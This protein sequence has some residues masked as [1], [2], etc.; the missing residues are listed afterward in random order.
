MN[1]FEETLSSLN[2]RQCEAVRADKNVVVTAGA[3]SGKTTVLSA[4]YAYLIM[5]RNLDTSQILTL[6]FTNKATNEMF[7]RIYKMLASSSTEESAQ[8]ALRNFYEA[9]I[10]TIDSFC[11]GLA[12]NGAA[13]FGISPDWKT[14]EAALEEL[15]SDAALAFVLER[16]DNHALQI[17]T[18]DKKINLISSGLFSSVILNETS[19]SN[20]VDFLA[21]LDEQIQII[22]SEYPALVNLINTQQMSVKKNPVNMPEAADIKIILEETEGANAEK[23]KLLNYYNMLLETGTKDQKN[24]FAP[25][26]NFVL[27]IKILKEIY[28]LLNDFQSLCNTQK[29]KTGLL[30]FNDVAQLAA[31]TLKKIPEIKQM[32]QNEIKA[33]MVDEFQD[34]NSAQKELLFLLAGNAQKLF[35]VGDEKQSIYRFRGADVSVFHELSKT[36]DSVHLETNYRSRSSLIGAFNILFKDIFTL[37]K[38]PENYDAEFYPLEAW[39]SAGEAKRAY[40]HFALFEEEKIPQNDRNSIKPI[41]VEA[42]YIAQK[43]NSIVRGN[44][45]LLILKKDANGESEAACSFEDIAVLLRRKTHQNELERELKR[46]DIPYNAE[47]PSSLFNDAFI[48]DALNFMRLL[49]YPGDKLSYMALLRSPFARLSDEALTAIVLMFNKIPFNDAPLD[50]LNEEDKKRYIKIKENYYELKKSLES[51]TVGIT[52]LLSILWNDFGYRFESLCRKG[53]GALSFDYFFELAVKAETRNKTLAQ[54]LHEIDSYKKQGF[55][56]DQKKLLPFDIPVE[57]DTGVRILTVHKSKGLEFPVVFIFDTAGTE[58][59]GKNGGA[60]FA[61]RRDGREPL[62]T[63]NL[64]QAAELN[65]K[66]PQNYFYNKF[67]NDEKNRMA[68]ELRRLVYVAA[69][70]AESELYWTGTI[71]KITKAELKASNCKEEPLPF[72]ERLRLYGDK[73]A[74]KAAKKENPSSILD[75]IAPVIVKDSGGFWDIEQIKYS[76]HARLKSDFIKQEAVLKAKQLYETAAVEDMPHTAGDFGLTQAASKNYLF[77]GEAMEAAGFGSLVH[78]FIETRLNGSGIAEEHQKSAR[79]REAEKL[80]GVFF[81]SELGKRALCAPFRVTEYPFISRI[82]NNEGKEIYTNGRVDLIFR[83]AGGLCIVDYKTDKNFE[84]ERYIEQLLIYR[85]AAEEI[86]GGK[87]TA[88][89]FYLRLNK[90]FRAENT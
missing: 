62:V 1:S 22:I 77:G 31:D 49:V 61:L 3:G 17:I 88:Y 78:N 72:M 59:A 26:V 18:G 11:A 52:E 83:D 32:Y 25:L 55:D 58:S 73:V 87:A 23:I 51:G 28:S 27:Q 19:V 9:K 66:K 40:M 47:E 35:F 79:F 8:K 74:K 70:R 6:T 2:P 71:P 16:R 89:L 48:N 29:R 33:I 15:I 68:A 4:R 24:D 76:K 65:G 42:S 12:K 7:E 80:A 75:L 45:P 64:P 36:I 44:P 56:A 13:F 53:K 30:S 67:K 85:N 37:K 38:T 39:R 84:P 81:D 46:L 43:I 5:R 21:M 57:R 34:N 41:E 86:F 10:Q 90:I 82:N 54:F 14:G 50:Y 20:P 69:T 63:I 60:Y